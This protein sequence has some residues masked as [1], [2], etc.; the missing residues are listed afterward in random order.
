MECTFAINSTAPG[1][2][3]IQGTFHT[4]KRLQLVHDKE[5]HKG[6]VNITDLPTGKYSVTV[7]DKMNSNASAYTHDELLQITN[8]PT[9][10]S[11]S[12][13]TSTTTFLSSSGIICIASYNDE[14]S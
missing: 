10:S 14:I 11:P 6:S 13:N 7:Y 2:V 3:L 8:E 5:S 1:F 4:G 9:E 12:F